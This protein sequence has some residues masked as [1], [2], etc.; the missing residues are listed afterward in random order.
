MEYEII[1]T[2]GPSSADEVIWQR[3]ISAGVTGFRLNTSHLSVDQVDLWIKKLLAFQDAIGVQFQLVL[4]LQGSKWRLGAFSPYELKDGQ[5]INLVFATKTKSQEELPVPHLDFFL[6]AGNVTGDFYLNDAKLHLLVVRKGEQ[7]IR[8]RVM[9]GGIISPGKGITCQAARRRE[10]LTAKDQ[11]LVERTSG[12]GFINYAISY[13]R[14]ALE[15]V[16]YREVI[17]K[18][19]YLVAKVERQPAIDEISGIAGSC[20]EVW[21]CRGD[22]GAELGD[23]AMAEAVHRVSGMVK[24]LAVPVMLAGQVLEHMTKEPAPTRSEMCY[25]YHALN[26]SYRGFV[27]SDET[28]VGLYPVESCQSAALFQTSH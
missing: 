6:S 27:L 13:V 10:S 23:K 18:E 28:S 21:L 11:E 20:D 2:L 1:A 15:M 19:K 26:L 25:L 9:R 16:R 8:T 24:D 12:L 17:G 5:E 7:W 22:L 14:D 4:D 3:M